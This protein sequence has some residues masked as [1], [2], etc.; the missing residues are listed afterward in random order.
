MPARSFTLPLSQWG[1]WLS[2]LLQRFGQWWMAEL[3][4]LFPARVSSWLMDRGSRM[5][6]VGH[7]ADAVVLHLLDDR[8][9]ALASARIGQA[10]FGPGTIDAFLGSHRLERAEVRLG[11]WLPP[12]RIFARRLVLPMETRRSLAAVVAQDLVAKTPFRPDDIFHDHVAEKRDGKIVVSQWVVRRSFVGEIAHSLGLETGELAFIESEPSGADAGPRPVLRLAQTPA[13]RSRWPRIVMLV[14]ATTA[15]LLTALALSLTYT[16]QQAMLESLAGEIAAVRAK[17]QSVRAAMDKLDSEWA[18]VAQVRTRKR[19][20]PGVLDVWDELTRILPTHS[21]L[22]ELRIS[23]TPGSKERHVL[24][25]G[26]SAAAATLVGLIEK[27]ALFADASLMSPISLDQTE[28]KE[29]FAIQATI[30]KQDQI[31]KASR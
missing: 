27:S 14:L 22:T 11:A 23:D 28:S 16:R 30:R 1:S 9:R 20:L 17:A 26:Y 24:I 12:E 3:L 19:D 13:D 31:E 2:G 10:E 7:D 29:R 6:L 8:R 15:L 25:T 21:W 4:A 18:S 5:L